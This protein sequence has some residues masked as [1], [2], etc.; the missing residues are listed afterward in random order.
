MSPINNTTIIAFVHLCLSQL[1]SM[2][3]CKLAENYITFNS[4][5]YNLQWNETVTDML[6]HKS[7]EQN[8]VDFVKISDLALKR[9]FQ[10]NMLNTI[11]HKTKKQLLIKK[12][13]WVYLMDFLS[14]VGWYTKN[15]YCPIKISTYD[16]PNLTVIILLLLFKSL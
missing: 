9:P 1:F 13:I 3:M 10:S 12:H 15:K 2:H 14:T 16:H 11:T 6:P 8:H 4:N 5:I 7:F